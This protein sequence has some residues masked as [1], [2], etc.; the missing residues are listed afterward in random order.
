MLVRFAHRF[1]SVR[2]AV[3]AASTVVL[4]LGLGY[5]F[6]VSRPG[7][8]PVPV[9]ALPQVGELLQWRTA[10]STTNRHEDGSI[11]TTAYAAPVNYQAADGSWQPIDPRLYR[12]NED[13]F[14]WRS[15]ANSYQMRFAPVAGDGFAELQ[16]AGRAIRVSAVG[17]GGGKATVDGSQ[18]SY[19]DAYAGV[20]LRYVVGATGVTKVLDLAGPQAA[21]AYTFRLSAVDGKGLSAQRR[22][23][24]S[25]VLPGLDGVVLDAPV[26]WQADRVP[27]P[28]ARPTLRVVQ[29]GKDLLVTVGLDAAWLRA[30]GRQ[31]PVHL[32]PTIT[33]QPDIRQAT[34]KTVAASTP[35]S[36][37]TLSVGSDSTNTYRSALQFDLSAVPAGAQVSSATLGINRIGCIT[38]VSQPC[39]TDHVLDV[40]RMTSAWSESSTY[41][42]LTFDAT[43][44]G[45]YTL[46]RGTAAGWMTWPITS[47]VT[48]WVNGTQP[49][50]GLLVKRR[51]E[52]LGS[53]GPTSTGLPVPKLD[54][55]YT[56]S[57]PYLNEPATLHADGAELSWTP[58]ATGTGTAGYEVHR[59]ASA[60]F[61]PSAATLVA[62]IGDRAQ[63]TYRDTTAAAN[64]TFTYRI[65]DLAD[66]TVSVPRTVTMPDAQRSSK[67][68]RPGPIDGKVVHLEYHDSS[69]CI[70]GP[71]S[72]TAKVGSQG[73]LSGV[74]KFRT[75]IGFDLRDIPPGA[76]ITSATLSLWRSYG[77]PPGLIVNA[78]RVTRPWKEGTGLPNCFDTSDGATWEETEPGL[79]WTADGGDHEGTPA[80]SVTVANTVAG[81]DQF[82]VT[83]LV[84]NWVNGDEPNH[85]LMLRIPNE[86]AVPG[87]A[88]YASDDDSRPALRP[89]LTVSYQDG[90]A[91]DGP[92]VVLSSPVEGARVAGVVPLRATAE[93]DRRVDLVEFLVN[94]VSVGSDNTAPF[95]TTWNT[96]AGVTNGSKALTVRASDDAGNIRLSSP[97]NVTVDNTAVPTG[98]LSAPSAGAVVAGDVTLTAT[99]SDDVGVTS[100]AFLVDGVRVGDP[101]TIA[102][103]S[104]TWKTL[105]PLAPTFDGVHDITALVT[106]T[107]G[108]QTTTVVR[109]VTVNNRGASAAK[110]EYKLNDPALADDD[111]FPS[112]M[113]A[114]TTTPV[115]Q[116]P[117]ASVPLNPDGTSG[118]SLGR[119][120]ASTPADNGSNPGTCAA[121]AY[122]PK[123]TVINRSG[124]AWTSSGAQVWYRWYAPNG[125]IMFEGRS[126]AAF[127]ATF[128][129]N[130]SHEFPLTIYP[131]ALP[132]GVEQGTYRLR[133]DV[134]DP[135][136]GAW[137]ATKGNA[138]I[139]NPVIVA[140]DLGTKMGLERFYQ[141]E[142]EP[143]GAGLSTMTNTANGNLLWRWSPYFAPGRGLATMV[144]LTYNSLQDHSQSP[145]GNNVSLAISGLIPVGSQLDI[146][147]NKADQISGQASKWVQ[148]AD[149]DG[150]VHRFTDGITGVDGITRFSEP[151]GVN[152]YLRSLPAADPRGRWA[153]TRPDNVTYI[154]DGDGYPTM[155]EDR[156]GNRITFGLEDTPAG[157]DPGGPKRRITAVTD[158]S[159]TRS[160]VIDYWSKDEIKK[161]HVRGKIQ[162]IRDYSGSKLDFEY[163]QDG[164]LRKLIERGGFNANGTPLADRA[165][166]FTYT[167]SNGAGPAIPNAA[168]RVDPADKVPNQSTRLFSI[169]DPRGAETTFAYYQA[170]DGQLLRWK[171][172]SRTNR[173]G[174]T[175]SLVYDPTN[176]IT[177]V[178][179]P[180][181]RV[182]KH[183]Y[184]VT[185]KVTRITDPLNQNTDVEWSTDFKVT[186]VT[187][188]S[189]GK[190]TRYDYNANGNL[191]LS[192]NEL[193]EQ[194]VLTYRDFGVDALDTGNHLSQ[195]LTVTKPKGVATP[196]PATD[197]Q[198]TYA[199]DTAGNVARITDPTGAFT[200]FVFNLAGS[201]HPGTL[202]EI[203]DANG[204]PATTFPSYDVSGQ[205]TE[206][207]DPLGRS[208]RFGYDVDGRTRWVQDRNHQNDTGSAEREYKTF[209]DYD[210]FGRLGRQS[211]PRS[212]ATLRGKLL[213]SSV[214]YDANDNTVKSI[215]AHFGEVDGDL[216]DGPITTATYDLMDRPMLITGPDLSADPAGER[217]KYDYDDAGRLQELTNPRGMQTSAVTGDFTTLYEYDALDRIRHETAYGL[218]TT[219]AQTRHTHACY[220][221]AGD[222]RSVTSPRANLASVTCPGDGPATAA[223]TT[224]FTYDIAHRRTIE[225]DPLGHETRIGYDANG[226]T[227]SRERD[228]ESGRIQRTATEFNQR[229]LP[230][231]VKERF[232]G[233][234]EAVTRFEYDSNGNRTKVHSP[235][236]IDAANAGQAGRYITEVRYDPLNRP[237]RVTLPFDAA[238]GTE[239]QYVHRAYDP[240]GNLLSTSLPVTSSTSAGPG[241]RTDMTY[242]DPGWIRTSDDPVNPKV[243]FGYTALGLQAS[244]TP[245]KT[246][247][248]GELDLN[249]LMSWAYHPDGM[250][251]SRSDRGGQSSLYHY[252]ANNNLTSATDADG[253]SDE[254]QKAVDIEA[255]YTGF[256]ELAKSRFRRT[257]QTVWTFSDYTYDANGN[258][259]VRRENGKEDG[260]TQTTAPRRYEMTYDSADWLTLQLD[261]GTDSACLDDQRIVNEFWG[262][263]WEKRREVRRAGTPCTSDSTT[264]PVKQVTTWNHFDNGLLK[265]LDTTNASG[266]VLESHDV[267][268]FDENGFFANANRTREHY[269]LKRGEGSTATTC[270]TTATACDAVYT[271]DARDRLISHQQ[272]AGVTTTY[273]LDQPGQLV[274]DTAVRGGNVTTE[275]KGG[276][277]TTRKYQANQLIEATTAGVTAKYWYL[278]LGD[279]DCITT[280]AGTQ[281][282][283]SPGG[284]GPASTNLITDH[285]YDYLSRLQ[286]T[287][288]YAGGGTLTDKATYVYDPLDRTVT[289][290]EDHVGTGKDH[291]TDFTYQGMTGLVTEE[292]QT[293]GTAA[294]TKTFAYDTYGRRLSMSDTDAA[295]R[296]DTYTYGHDVHS[297]VSQLI[298]DAGI[299]KA[300]YGYDAYGGTD[301]PPGGEALTAGDTDA[302]APLNPFRYAGK[303]I[304]SGPANAASAPAGYDMGARRYAPDLGRFLQQDMYAGALSNLGLTLDPLTQNRYAL[305]GGNPISYIELDGHAVTPDGGGGGSSSPAPAPPADPTSSTGGGGCSGSTPTSRS[306][307]CPPPSSGG[308][309]PG[310]QPGCTASTPTSR[311]ASCPAFIAGPPPTTGCS[312][313][314][315]TTR[316]ADCPYALPGRDVK[317]SLI[318][319]C[320][321]AYVGCAL[322]NW[323]QGTVGIC[324]TFDY[325]LVSH[326]AATGCVVGDKNG[327]FTTFTETHP[328]PAGDPRASWGWGLGAGP[329]IQISDATT[330]NSLAEGGKFGSGT[331]VYSYTY[332]QT[333]DKEGRDVH[334]N[335][336]GIGKGLPVGGSGGG[337]YTYVSGYLFEGCGWWIC[338]I[339]N[340][341]K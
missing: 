29:Q 209:Y 54:I 13:G 10:A 322:R 5:W 326:A 11:T 139:D 204:N 99:T 213:W 73:D 329:S 199:Y 43:A 35:V 108:Q 105:D 290:W 312:G 243:H 193:D 8:A 34:F 267:T 95:D 12:A 126:A 153:L 120:L 178:T 98:S 127:P 137:F 259:L 86:Q 298:T 154:F 286:G 110:V 115:V 229:D 77:A 25:Y 205:P 138:P 158:P 194:T 53:N 212:T 277:T 308:S 165:F 235:R 325:G 279:L 88:A 164:N 111:V 305:A 271:Y 331:I 336:Y 75:V 18:I 263:G 318:A 3:A 311:S 142:G 123:V 244:R 59:S 107:S 313:S 143:V 97:V 211:E 258:V 90:S 1:R 256:D 208:T 57:G 288:Q 176:R 303:R 319:S 174:K 134:F 260:T 254:S 230:E 264:W 203:W 249:L 330:K 76:Q 166:V 340:S 225:R 14:A 121:A 62:R 38:S 285:A 52:S 284:D 130:A 292:K 42:Q 148:F 46:V 218:D 162:Q 207:K 222:L 302:Q 146:H 192:A 324:F 113:A 280:A 69:P 200:R 233:S 232:D 136:T 150:T 242:F 219:A 131:P 171:L 60:S 248:P 87:L 160:F 278:P 50:H 48:A 135:A 181:S 122:C 227:T 170:T 236:A 22:S 21:T 177:T 247:T 45:S 190:F 82:A 84:Q 226:N 16:T 251:S 83:G 169:R 31:F 188:V 327:L 294:K 7:S 125:A 310:V 118:G 272:R 61:T 71:K 32:D 282:D 261:L 65:K 161:A 239:R 66:S 252:D 334:I 103:Y 104:I 315:P 216:E 220:D 6:Q 300:S 39:G 214:E 119:A 132:P 23:D 19:P 100:V 96:T 20:N 291:Q 196:T 116:D 210:E 147:P 102:P 184:D 341:T 145:A 157:E 333:T 240:N 253:I 144:D 4:A 58:S 281:A 238:D 156:N 27:D 78:H 215:G 275:T 187:N 70:D 51:T 223:F 114:N 234:R 217:T 64:G 180:L 337:N 37:T 195:V 299:V 129:D 185:G 141:Y 44:S 55:T 274:G 80:A 245:E 269:V 268:Y 186:K 270:V 140:K 297:S 224:T 262:T 257:D 93:D 197:Y 231:F 26:V 74:N 56:I 295:G 250:V 296:T 287:R 321:E 179:A 283:C 40:H 9:P 81:I 198:W 2:V 149:G 307:S 304:D 30:P 67:V 91:A 273:T 266:T 246:T 323:G 33:V 316:S 163:Y 168:D 133:V 241:A 173:A 172:K 175:T 36:L 265:D 24:G 47:L 201:A 151:A 85:G 293:G 112:V 94:G 276:V 306:A 152:L 106:D 255:T 49:N 339:G 317:K 182:T 328:G 332:S 301:A 202:K 28:A 189:T 237:D 68:L 289:E 191:K 314:T 15:G 155:V 17:A 41:S 72:P 228:I 79:R 101:D 89:K 128:A 63:R 206:V 221:L 320:L 309:G 92:R 109:S 117:Y 338:N 159:G 183:T 167:T 124:T 335:D